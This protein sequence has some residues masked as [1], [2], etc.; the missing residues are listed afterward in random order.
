MTAM[1]YA[2]MIAGGIAGSLLTWVYGVWVDWPSRRARRS[3]LQLPG[4]R[5]YRGRR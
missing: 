1:F 4:D 2:G 3:R 5:V